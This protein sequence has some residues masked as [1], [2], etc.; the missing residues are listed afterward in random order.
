MKFL[1]VAP[2]KA[3][4]TDVG[5]QR[6][7]VCNV[8]LHIQRNGSTIYKPVPCVQCRTVKQQLVAPIHRFIAGQCRCSDIEEYNLACIREELVLITTLSREL[9]YGNTDVLVWAVP[10]HILR[11]EHPFVSAFRIGR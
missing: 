9:R 7:T 11:T 4:F 3:A 5:K 1:G 2:P 8:Y 6:Y 10:L